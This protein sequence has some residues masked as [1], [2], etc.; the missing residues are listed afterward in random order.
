VK[1]RTIVFGT[2]SFL[3][4][5]YAET[6][7]PDPDDRITAT[8]KKSIKDKNEGSMSLSFEPHAPVD[9]SAFRSR[10]HFRDEQNS[11]PPETQ[12]SGLRIVQNR[13]GNSIQTEVGSALRDQEIIN[14]VDRSG[15]VEV[16][17]AYGD[18][19][20]TLLKNLSKA[21]YEKGKVKTVFTEWSKGNGFLTVDQMESGIKA[22]KIDF[23]H[24]HLVA[25]FEQFDTNNSNSLTFSEFVRILSK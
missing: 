5:H 13:P 24:E 4:T 19:P 23:P 10:R 22:M 9:N 12:R 11:E 3:L 20:P 7:L 16:E 2:S 17:S 15:Y 6:N 8:R 25:L 14:G 21:V 1:T 18:I